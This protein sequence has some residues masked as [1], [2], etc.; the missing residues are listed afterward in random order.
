MILGRFKQALSARQPIT[1]DEIHDLPTGRFCGETTLSPVFDGAGACAFVLFS[2]NDVTAKR[3]ADE[4]LAR[5][6]ESRRHLE[7]QSAAGAQASGDPAPSPAASAHDFNNI[8]TAIMGNAELLQFD[9]PPGSRTG[10]YAR[11]IVDASLRARDLIKQMMAFSRRQRQERT[12]GRL[13]PIIAAVVR[14]LQSTLPRNIEIRTELLDEEPDV[15]VD[16]A[17]MQQALMNLCMNA[18]HAMR[19]Q[20]GRLTVRRNPD[21]A[22]RAISVGLSPVARRGGMSASR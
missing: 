3:R 12:P 1:Y 10:E 21:R 4:A 19:S 14:L 2:S 15:L 22:G 17:Q 7:T 20:G 18:A 6:V 11:E 9:L 5:S 8:L 13:A 16:A